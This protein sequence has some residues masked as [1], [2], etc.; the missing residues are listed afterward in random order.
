MPYWPV[1]IIEHLG[2]LG[3][4]RVRVKWLNKRQAVQV[5]RVQDLLIGE[6]ARKRPLSVGDKVRVLFFVLSHELILHYF[7]DVI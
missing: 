1:L 3:P 7:N 4:D 6:S 5:M 2:D